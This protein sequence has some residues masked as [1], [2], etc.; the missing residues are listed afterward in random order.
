MPL[1]ANFKDSESQHICASGCTYSKA[2]VLF[3]LSSNLW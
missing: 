2:L 3:A 1:P